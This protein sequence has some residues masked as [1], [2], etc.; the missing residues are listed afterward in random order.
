ML[1]NTNNVLD[2]LVE[3]LREGG[4]TRM[5]E[6]A[7][8]YA[9]SNLSF[10]V[11]EEALTKVLDEILAA[12]NAFDKEEALRVLEAAPGR[13]EVTEPEE[14]EDEDESEDEEGTDLVEGDAPDL[15]SR[16]TALEAEVA[17]LKE[18]ASRYV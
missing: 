12:L 10:E 5:R 4:E 18:I 1:F 6:F 17:T 14:E 2:L 3:A 8:E 16:V 13:I 11:D 9:T 15:A 7:K